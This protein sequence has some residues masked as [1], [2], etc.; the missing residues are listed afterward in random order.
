[1]NIR[2]TLSGYGWTF[3]ICAFFGFIL[4]SIAAGSIVPAVDKFAA[5]WLVCSKGTFEIHQDTYSYRPGESDTMTTDYCVDNATGVKT[6]VSFQTMIVAGLVYSVVLFAIVL[7]FTLVNR[8]SRPSTAETVHKPTAPSSSHAANKTPK[9]T[10]GSH[11]KRLEELKHMYDTNLINE[12]EYEEKKK[13]ILD[14][15]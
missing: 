13:Q 3:L 14:E 7:V 9:A 10:G 6:D 2:K 5:G 11:E 12:Q 8:R 1:M 15:I 4:C